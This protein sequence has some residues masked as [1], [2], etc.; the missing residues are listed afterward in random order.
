[1]A[2]V[3]NLALYPIGTSAL[4]PLSRNATDLDKLINGTGTVE[5]RAGGILTTWQKLEADFEADTV[6]A[7]QRYSAL[8]NTG[9]WVTATEYEPNDLWSYDGNWYIV[10]TAYTSG[11]T[12]PDD[13][14]GGNVQIYPVSGIVWQ[15]TSLTQ[16]KSMTPLAEGQ[17]I[18]LSEGGRYGTFS[19]DSGDL[20]AQVLSDPSEGVYITKEGEDG[21]SGAWVRQF[22]GNIDLEWFG[23]VLNDKESTDVAD[24]TNT[25][26]IQSAVS[27]VRSLQDERDRQLPVKLVGR[28]L[29][30]LDAPLELADVSVDFSELQIRPKRNW[31]GGP[32][33]IQVGFEG[34][35]S[36]PNGLDV[37]LNVHGNHFIQ[38]N[39][40][41]PVE[42]EMLRLRDVNSATGKVS[43][44]GSYFSTLVSI[45]DNTESLQLDIEAVRGWRVLH[46]QAINTS[47]SPDSNRVFIKAKEVGLFHQQTPSSAQF[48]GDYHYDTDSPWRMSDEGDP[49][50]HNH[51]DGAHFQLLTKKTARLSGIIRGDA[52]PAGRF[53]IDD[54]GVFGGMYVFNDLVIHGGSHG[55]DLI[56]KSA[57]GLAGR[58]I[59]SR[60][61]RNVSGEAQVVIGENYILNDFTIDVNI[62]RADIA[63]QIGDDSFGSPQSGSTLTVNHIA[64]GSNG[65]DSLLF[66]TD[67]ITVKTNHLDRNVNF[68]DKIRNRVIGMRSG[69]ETT[70]VGEGRIYN[71]VGDRVRVTV[72]DTYSHLVYSEKNSTR[73]IYGYRP[74]GEPVGTISSIQFEDVDI[75]RLNAIQV[76]DS[77]A[78]S[79]YTVF[80]RTLDDAAGA[81]NKTPAN[82]N[83]SSSI[84]IYYEDSDGVKQGPI[85]APWQVS[86]EEYQVTNQALAERFSEVSEDVNKLALELVYSAT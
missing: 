74:D 14:A 79:D 40:P 73:P 36:F 33:V 61:S 38:D 47:K 10:L 75:D 51:P 49:S 28:G 1:M 25:A 39:E 67:G 19:W 9:A 62:S 54:S 85:N 72:P 65:T 27:F 22:H 42:F 8:N 76:S 13:I 78:V 48:S 12:A 11:A 5:N 2:G 70:D 15:A 18:Q 29:L 57:R 17:V 71:E 31:D 82:G 80:I 24:S 7:L 3:T 81:R 86:A 35:P 84:N 50:L 64:D 21:S 34:A 63:V 32:Y 68:S 60:N 59:L 43:I 37:K 66:K 58:V 16:M 52:D 83:T 55:P 53:E 4:A 23:V 69:A 46:E 44:K 6:D 26:R 45:T 56:A 30:V 77:G 41:Q 20:S